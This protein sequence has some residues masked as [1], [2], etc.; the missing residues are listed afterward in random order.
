MKD[1]SIKSFDQPS[2]LKIADQKDAKLKKA[3]IDFEAL[4]TYEMLKSMRKSI[5]KCDLFH[6]GQAEEIYESMLDQ[7]LSQNMAGK[8]SNSI[9]ET[10]YNQLKNINLT[11]QAKNAI[12]GTIDRVRETSTRPVWPLDGKI[13]SSFGFRKDPFTGKRKFHAGMD[14]AAKEG[15]D[16]KAVMS[17]RVQMVDEQ[18]GY[19]KVLVLDHGEGYATLYA[20]NS[21]I[22]VKSGDWVQKGAIIAKVGSTGRSTGP[23]LHFEVRKDGQRLDPEKFFKL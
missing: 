1:I 4:F 10:L 20:H 8:G 23:H 18:K 14:L 17:G 5:E 9:S 15:S 19:G 11:E 6:G 2:A 16:I 22:T 7:E 3:C 21:D 13:S 12:P